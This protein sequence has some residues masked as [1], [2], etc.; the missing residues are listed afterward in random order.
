LPAL[1]LK[2]SMIECCQLHQAGM[3]FAKTAQ[4]CQACEMVHHRD[5][6]NGPGLHERMAA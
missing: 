2:L 6:L 5:T 3:R 4:L 1:T